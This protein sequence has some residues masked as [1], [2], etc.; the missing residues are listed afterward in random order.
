M[1]RAAAY[2]LLLFYTVALFKPVIP[3]VSDVLAHQFNKVNHV[4]QVHQHKGAYHLHQELKE[5]SAGND[6]TSDNKVLKIS[7][8]VSI[9]IITAITQMDRK[10]FSVENSYLN[11]V[12]ALLNTLLQNNTPPPKA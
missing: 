11:T 5:T 2:Y 10:E 1:K 12:S 3:I 6:E 8:P 7:E 4:L 9:H